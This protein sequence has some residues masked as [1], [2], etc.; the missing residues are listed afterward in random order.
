MI[1]ANQTNQ[2]ES[3]Y[4]VAA[5]TKQVIER[6]LVN[7]LPKQILSPYVVAKMTDGEVSYVAAEPPEVVQQRAFLDQRKAMLEKGLQTFR[8]AMGGLRR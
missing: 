7:P 1:A 3:K 2:D 8:E 5:V 6:Y 4:F